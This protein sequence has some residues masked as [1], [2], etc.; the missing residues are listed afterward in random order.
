MHKQTVSPWTHEKERLE[1]E[2]FQSIHEGLMALF[3]K[4]PEWQAEA[5]ALHRARLGAGEPCVRCKEEVA[6]RHVPIEE[7]HD[8]QS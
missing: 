5:E 3:A 2:H 1:R 8:C 4:H 6:L 7:P